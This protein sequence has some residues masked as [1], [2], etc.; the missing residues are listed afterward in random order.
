VIA[1]WGKNLYATYRACH[2][3][4]LE[5]RAVADNSP[6]FSG[7][8]YRDVQ[9]K[10]DPCAIDAQTDGIVLSNI[11]PAQVDARLSGLHRHFDGP[12]LRLWHPRHLND[13][14][15]RNTPSINQPQKVLAV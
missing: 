12:I 1:D 15:L 9:L 7:M 14:V 8:R 11:N 4:E 5:I 13:P 10:T 3:A 2:E 6:A